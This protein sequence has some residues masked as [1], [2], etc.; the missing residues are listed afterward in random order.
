LST[1]F[2][3]GHE[4]CLLLEKNL[5]PFGHI[6]HTEREGFLWDKGPHVSFTKSDY[7]RELFGSS[8]SSEFEEHEVVTGNYFQGHWVDH[9][10]QTSASV[11]PGA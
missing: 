10:A 2:H 6:G 3:F 5:E 9:P 1:S 7:V 4:N 11:L 8:V